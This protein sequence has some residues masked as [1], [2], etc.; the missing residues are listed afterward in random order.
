MPQL[1]KQANVDVLNDFID[2]FEPEV[3][4]AALGYDLSV[5]FLEGLDVGSD[6]AIAQKWLDLRDGC[7]FTTQAGIKKRW[8]GFANNET[9][10]S[11]MA[12]VIYTEMQRDKATDSSGIGEVNP[13][14]EN[15]TQ[16]SPTIKMSRAWFDMHQQMQVLWELLRKNATTYTQYAFQQINYSYFK[17]Q[18]QFGI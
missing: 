4:E 7:V 15:S 9:K 6:E 10:K 14:G 11:V 1:G 18:N 8:I 3:L 2:R 13:Q 5:A 12:G 17:G 16:A